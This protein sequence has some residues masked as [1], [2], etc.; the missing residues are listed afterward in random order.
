MSPSGKNFWN[1]QRLQK[2]TDVRNLA[3]YVFAVVVL[4][5]TWSGVRAVQKNYELQ[6]KIEAIKQENEVIKLENQNAELLNKY[7]GT[8]QYLELTARQDL[9]LAAPGEK[10][11]LIPKNVAL[12]YLH[13]SGRFQQNNEQESP[14]SKRSGYA[15]NLEDWRNF[16]LGRK[17]PDD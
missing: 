1:R 3:L 4:A 8:E 15:K 14:E 10:V 7:L 17:L 5:I 16:L 13:P 12:K 6:K 9:G 11:I 2:L